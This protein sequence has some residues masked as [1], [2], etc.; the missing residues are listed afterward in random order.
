MIAQARVNLEVFAVV[1]KAVLALQY[2]RQVFAVARVAALQMLSPLLR[3]VLV[4][5]L[6]IVGVNVDLVKVRARV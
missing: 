5:V 6:T 4:K 1:L 3:F 2:Y